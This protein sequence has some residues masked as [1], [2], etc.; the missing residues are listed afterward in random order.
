MRVFFVSKFKNQIGMR[1][2]SHD[3]Y[4]IEGFPFPEIDIG[5]LVTNFLEFV[6]KLIDCHN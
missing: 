1:I 3:C 6:D 4:R 5:A 2:H